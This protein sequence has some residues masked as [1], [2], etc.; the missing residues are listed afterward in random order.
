MCFFRS[1]ALAGALW[2]ASAPGDGGAAPAR[3]P[4]R[5]SSVG[6][7]QT[8]AT[9]TVVVLDVAKVFKNHARFKQRMNAIRT[10][11]DRYDKDVA[12]EHQEI[13][14]RGSK[15]K[16]FKSGSAEYKKIVEQADREIA[17]LRLRAFARKRAFFD[18]EGRIYYD[19]YQEVLAAVTHLAEIHNISLV[20]KYDSA[21]TDPLER[22]SILKAINRDVVHQSHLDITNLVIERVNGL[23]VAAVPKQGPK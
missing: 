21:E 23:S 13:L 8:S 19:T 5:E 9:P 6:T 15:V 17:E 7:T 16:D 14:A 12:A 4:T 1:A 2:L 22:G 10:E 18:R 11:V 20:L 3:V